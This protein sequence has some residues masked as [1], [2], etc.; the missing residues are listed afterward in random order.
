M[1]IL[2]QLQNDP[3][4]TLIAL[5]SPALRP[6]LVEKLAQRGITALALDAVPRISRAQSMY[7]SVPRALEPPHGIL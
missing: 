4:A 6:D 1:G 5:L 7:P 2:S 3:R